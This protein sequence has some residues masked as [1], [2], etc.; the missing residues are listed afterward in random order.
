MRGVHYL[1]NAVCPL[2]RNPHPEIF[3]PTHDRWANTHPVIAKREAPWQ[4]RLSG[5]NTVL[6][7]FASLAMTDT[8]RCLDGGDGIYLA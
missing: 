4:S 7:C 3:P 6:D 1:E 5:R 2:Y 8:L